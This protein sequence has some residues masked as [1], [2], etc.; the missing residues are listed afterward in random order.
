MLEHLHKLLVIHLALFLEVHD[1]VFKA[2]VIGLQ[3]CD[4]SL[5]ACY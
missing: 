3:C 1:L 2:C 4:T 5:E